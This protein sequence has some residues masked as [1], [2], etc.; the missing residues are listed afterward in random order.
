MGTQYHGRAD[1]GLSDA[2]VCR[3]D[4]WQLQAMAVLRLKVLLGPGV[5]AGLALLQKARTH[6]GLSSH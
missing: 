3:S 4:W 6:G 5:K 1:Q 2:V